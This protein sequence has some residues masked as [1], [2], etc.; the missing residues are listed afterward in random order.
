MNKAELIEQISKKTDISKT[1]AEK[2]LSAVLE[3]IME[4]VKKDQ[5]QLVGFGTFKMVKSKARE[6]INPQTGAKIHIPEKISL[7][8]KASKNPKY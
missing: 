8:F 5:V 3:S 4:G 1:E 7:K 2:M 6:G